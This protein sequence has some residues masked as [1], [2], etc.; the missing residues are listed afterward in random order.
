MTK[1]IIPLSVVHAAAT[2]SID[3][4]QE[5]LESAGFMRLMQISEPRLSEL[6]AKYKAKGYDVEV[7]PLVD[8]G[9]GSTPLPSVGCGGA[10]SCSSGQGAG[11]A[12]SGCSSGGCGSGA[13]QARPL[14]AMAPVARR[15]PQKFVAGVGTI[16]VRMHN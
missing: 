15:A 10:S 4:L 9:D 16:Y 14:A 5:R 13:A 6:I 11:S 12:A 8:E 7:L 3:D 2:E 1:K